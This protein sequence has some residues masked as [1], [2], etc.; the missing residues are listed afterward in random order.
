[1]C[2]G[3][4]FTIN[5]IATSPLCIMSIKHQSW[6]NQSLINIIRLL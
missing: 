3:G 5:K 2:F 4:G 1:M 6:S